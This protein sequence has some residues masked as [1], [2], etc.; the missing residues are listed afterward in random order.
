MR[1]TLL[2][3]RIDSAGLVVE[4]TAKIRC[5]NLPDCSIGTVVIRAAGE[6]VSQ[7]DQGY[8]CLSTL[9]SLMS[10]PAVEAS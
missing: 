1:E 6:V 8:G 7:T 5:N 10:I 4:V 3:L 2:Y 9:Q